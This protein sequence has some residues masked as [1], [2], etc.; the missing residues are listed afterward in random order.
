[1][2]LFKVCTWWTSQC[3]DYESSYDLQSLHCCRFGIGEREK[4]YIIVGS[5]SGYVSVFMPNA[6][7][8]DNDSL[9]GFRPTDQLLE[10]KLSHPILQVTSGKFM[11]YE[12]STLYC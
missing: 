11:M 12:T 4:D 5:H 9:S 7:N 1:M 2:S 6:T 8:E 3:P 10:I